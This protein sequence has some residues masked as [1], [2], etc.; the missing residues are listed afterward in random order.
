MQRSLSI[1]WE[2]F[3]RELFSYL[4]DFLRSANFSKKLTLESVQKRVYLIK[5]EIRNEYTYDWSDRILKLGKCDDSSPSDQDLIWYNM[6]WKLATTR[7]CYWRCLWSLPLFVS[8]LVSFSLTQQGGECMQR[9][10]KDW[11]PA[12]WPS[13]LRTYKLLSVLTT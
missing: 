11:D 12:L 9:K 10:M 13:H 5:P 3:S 1:M 2:G 7:R 6:N 8:V 4:V